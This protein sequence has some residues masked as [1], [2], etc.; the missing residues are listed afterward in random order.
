YSNFNE[1]EEQKKHR[2]QNLFKKT[3]AVVTHLKEK[4]P[5]VEFYKTIARVPPDVFYHQ[6]ETRSVLDVADDFENRHVH[7]LLTQ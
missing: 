6:L 2:L 5:S 1:G 7:R 3:S 4:N